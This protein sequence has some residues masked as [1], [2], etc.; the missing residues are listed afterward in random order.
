MEQEARP[1]DA[2]GCFGAKCGNL[3]LPT[4]FASA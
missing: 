4:N 1:Q 2:K 3:S